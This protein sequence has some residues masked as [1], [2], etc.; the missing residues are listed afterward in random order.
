MKN[1][2]ILICFILL[3]F[4]SYISAEEKKNEEVTWKFYT[5]NKSYMYLDYKAKDGSQKDSF[6][7][8]STEDFTESKYTNYSFGLRKTFL[9]FSKKNYDDS[10]LD[11][12]YQYSNELFNHSWEQWLDRIYFK[13]QWKPVEFTVGDFYESMNRGMAFSMKNDPVYGDNSIR[14][15]NI[16]S[17][18]KS[19]QL[20]AFG[21]R[22]NPQIRDKATFQR[23][24]ETDDWLAGF[25]GGYKWKK[26]EFGVQYGYGNYGKYNLGRKNEKNAS[27]KSWVESEKEFHFTGAY[28]ALKNPFPGFTYYAG[29][30]YVPYAYENTILKDSYFGEMQPGTV[31]KTD[32][33]NAAA[34]YSSAL[35]F[36]DFGKKKSRLTFK[37]E[38]KFY[39]KYFLNYTRM[40]DTNYK[41]RYFNPP[42]LLP[43]DLE[44][45]NEFDTWAV[46]GRISLNDKSLTKAKYNIDFVKGDSLDNKD[47]VPSY[48]SDIGG[49]FSYQKEDFWYLAGSGEK[50]FGKVSFSA[51][52]GYHSVKG[53]FNENEAADN[54]Q[55]LMAGLHVSG[56]VSKLSI[57]FTNDYYLKNMKLAGNQ[58]FDNANELK[59]VLDVSWDKKYFFAIKNT[60]WHNENPG[61]KS[62]NWYTGGSVGYRYD[63]LRLYLFGGLEKGGLSC[64]G[65]MCRYLPDFKGVKAELDISL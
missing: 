64:D 33:D 51:N 57:K 38:G 34:F 45:D 52:I 43:S 42:T 13:G 32:L 1:S 2:V 62:Q 21:G 22:A 65:G 17:S 4:F 39:N 29:A 10:M 36:F 23:M 40:E 50:D 35:Y 60:Y 61:D 16:T 30:V 18:F 12:N 54:R 26:A 55:W 37:L 11:H 14:G 6:G 58:E 3:L 46:G 27:L 63:S 8:L 48:R 53:N 49:N 59:T 47:A 24:R 20:K 41:R 5:K 15:G 19:F 28:I 56:F 25:E 44:I 31:E 7:V 9:V